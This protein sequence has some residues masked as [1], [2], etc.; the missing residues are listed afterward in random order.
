MELWSDG[1]PNSQYSNTPTLQYSISHY[2][3]IFISATMI[4]LFGLPFQMMFRAT[5]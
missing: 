5:P 4:S 1:P 3:L 2:A